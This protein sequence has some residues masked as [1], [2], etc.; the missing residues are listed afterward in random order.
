MISYSSQL[1]KYYAKTPPTFVHLFSSRDPALAENMEGPSKGPPSSVSYLSHYNPVSQ[2]STVGLVLLSLRKKETDIDLRS[3]KAQ[4]SLSTLAT[5]TVQCLESRMGDT[6]VHRT[7]PCEL[8]PR[9]QPDPASCCSTWLSVLLAPRS[10][11]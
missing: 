10:S 2:M 1:N 5:W 8:L 3:P 6:V 7:F 11:P 9:P 4:S